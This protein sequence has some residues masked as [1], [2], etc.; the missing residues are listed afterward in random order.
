MNIF[1][2]NVINY[3]ELFFQIYTQKVDSLYFYSS[4]S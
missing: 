1:L 2:N 4:Y 3:F